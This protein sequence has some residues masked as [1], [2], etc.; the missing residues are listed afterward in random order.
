M[1]LCKSGKILNWKY[2]FKKFTMN[3]IS[4]SILFLFFIVFTSCQQKS[5]DIKL[6]DLKEVCDYVNAADIVLDEM[7]AFKKEHP[8]DV[9]LGFRSIM[10]GDPIGEYKSEYTAQYQALMDKFTEIEEAGA[11]KYTSKELNECSGLEKLLIKR[12]SAFKSIEVTQDMI[13]EVLKKK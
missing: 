4:V 11:R 2:Q 5:K 12:D 9:A 7:I 8:K 10:V 1:R 6:G 13:N 3:K